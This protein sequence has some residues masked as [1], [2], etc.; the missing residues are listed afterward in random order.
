MLRPLSRPIDDRVAAAFLAALV[1][2]LAAACSPSFRVAQYPTNEALYAAA[3]NQFQD[4]KWDNAVTAFERLTLQLPPR[5]TLLPRSHF[6][7]GMAH[8][9][10]R[11]ELLAAQSFVR[12]V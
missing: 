11:E 3:L 8:K 12:L 2:G 5:D 1:L 4:R 9:G 10:R 7:L 6:Y